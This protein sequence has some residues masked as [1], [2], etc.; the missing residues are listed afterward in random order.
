ATKQLKK[1]DIFDGQS[2]FMLYDTYGFP[3]DLTQDILRA[4]NIEIDVKGFDQAMKNQQKIARA[5][6]TGSG[7]IKTDD[8]WVNLTNQLETKFLGYDQLECHAKLRFMINKVG[9]QISALNNGERAYIIF[10]QSPFYGESGGQEGD[11]GIIRCD[12]GEFIVEDTQIKAGQLIVHYGIWH[13]NEPLNQGMQCKL[14]IDDERR[15]RLKRNHSATH[16]LH[17]ALRKVLGN[18]VIQKGSLVR[19]NRFRFDFTHL[20]ALTQKEIIQIEDLIN[21][22]IVSNGDVKIMHMPF[23][24]AVKGGA[25]ALF[26]EKYPSNVRVLAMGGHKKDTTKSDDNKQNALSRKSQTDPQFDAWSV[27]L[28]GGTH[29]KKLGDIGMVRIISESGIASGIR[30]IE[31]V[32][33]EG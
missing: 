21:Q 16:L 27:E 3:L 22:Q 15:T 14:E 24:E 23:S 12:M 25:I 28:C 29:V 33:I 19:E 7:E 17:Q 31:A 8:I 11:K 18:H 6:W 5:S 4:Q 30:R 20:K 26:G 9:T 32:S 13:G 10:E 1:G 2:A